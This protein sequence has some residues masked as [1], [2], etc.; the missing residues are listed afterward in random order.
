MSTVDEPAGLREAALEA[1]ATL[2]ARHTAREQALSVSRGVIRRCA[3]AIRSI[4]RHEFEAAE[5]ALDGVS[6]D[7]GKLRSDLQAHADIYWSGYVQDCLK[8]Y[9]EARLTL[10]LVRRV[11]LPRPSELSVDVAAYLNGLGE[12][13]GELR[14]HALDVLRHG[15]ADQAEYLLDAMSDVYEVLVTVDYPDAVTGGLRRTTDNVRGI[16]ERTRGDITFARR[17]E[18]LERVLRQAGG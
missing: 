17:Q 18:R 10:A 4:H 2:E 14:R 1:D 16:L 3:N 9:A 11:P 13:V 12:A 15:E 6:V 8:E 5:A 7:L